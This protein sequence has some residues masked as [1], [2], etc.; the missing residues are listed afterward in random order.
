MTSSAHSPRF[1]ELL[2]AY[3]LG[4]LD[5]DELRELAA[6][7]AAGCP[8]CEGELR[9]L[10]AEVEDLAAAATELPES[11]AAEAPEI[12]GGVK[13]RLLAELPRQPRLQQLAE[14]AELAPAPPAAYP[15]PPAHGVRSGRPG[16]SGPSGRRWL[17]LAAAAVLA[18]VAAWGVVRQARMGAEIERLRGES[19]QLVARAETLERRAAQA[20]A[21]SQRLARTISILAAPGVQS[22]RLAGMGTSHAAAGRTYVDAADRRA[23][24]YASGLPA[25]GPDKTYQLWYLDDQDHPTSAGV[26]EVDAHG[27]A[28]LVVDQSLPVER[29]QAW[30]VTIEPRGGRPQPTGPM[31]L[32]G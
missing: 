23:V 11:L 25:L 20:Q 26:F 18:L 4:A 28:A 16:R 32:A 3:A 9:R 15:S 5:G 7:L 30:A 13:R 2:P 19:R 21:E 1:D 17:P 12:L 27:K 31:A 29:I 24:F 8:A 14:V 10:A 6:H 22:V